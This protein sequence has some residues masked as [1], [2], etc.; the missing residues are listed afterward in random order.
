MRNMVLKGV[1]DGLPNGRF[2]PSCT[3]VPSSKAVRRRWPCRYRSR[4][5]AYGSWAK[6]SEFSISNGST[7]LLTIANGIQR[8]RVVVAVLKADRVKD[9][10]NRM[11]QRQTRKKRRVGRVIKWLKKKDG[12]LLYTKV[13]CR[14]RIYSDI[15]YGVQCKKE[16]RGRGSFICL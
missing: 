6:E 13:V 8:A 1:V 3:K 11:N 5:A 16:R 15:K 9:I 12:G 10:T 4:F 2:Q 7:V 14:V